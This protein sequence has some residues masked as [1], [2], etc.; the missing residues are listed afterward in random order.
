MSHMAISAPVGVYVQ[1]ASAAKQWLV[2]F[3]RICLVSRHAWPMPSLAWGF[4]S[5][6]ALSHSASVTGFHVVWYVASQSAS[7]ASL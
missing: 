3:L 4:L 6:G 7:N 2:W 5:A 1:P